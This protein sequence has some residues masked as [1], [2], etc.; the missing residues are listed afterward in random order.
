MANSLPGWSEVCEWTKEQLND[1]LCDIGMERSSG[2]KKE[3]RDLVFE[4]LAKSIERE[5]ESDYSVNEDDAHVSQSEETLLV[6]GSKEVNDHMSGTTD[7]EVEMKRMQL[8]KM[9]V[10]LR[11][12]EAKAREAQIREREA[13]E[14]ARLERLEREKRLKLLD[15][16]E[17]DRQNRAN[18]LDLNKYK[19]LPNF[20][21]DEIE[22]FFA[23]F[24]R[25][26]Q[27]LGWAKEHWHIIVGTVL[28]GKALE[29][30]QSLPI[31]D[32]RN[33]T[34]LKTEILKKYALT[35]EAYRQQFRGCR[36]NDQETFRQFADRIQS[37]FD[38]WCQSVGASGSFEKLREAV[39]VEQFNNSIGNNLKVY[40]AEREV[41]EIQ[42]AARLADN[43]SLIHGDANNRRPR[44]A[45]DRT[46]NK[47]GD[48]LPGGMESQSQSQRQSQRGR[49]RVR[50]RR[51]NLFTCYV[52][53][54]PG[55]W[56]RNC[57][58]RSAQV[59]ATVVAVPSVSFSKH[60]PGRNRRVPK[61]SAGSARVSVCGVPDRLQKCAGR[62]NGSPVE[63]MLDS[64][65]STV[66]VR[67][68]LV[69][70]DQVTGRSFHCRQFDGTTVDLPTAKVCLDT[71]VFKGLVEA[72]MIDHPVSDVI[73]G[74][75][76][77]AKFECVEVAG[78]ARRVNQAVQT[79]SVETRKQVR[80]EG[81]SVNE[82]LEKGE[83]GMKMEG[84]NGEKRV[85][86]DVNF[87]CGKVGIEKMDERRGMLAGRGMDESHES[88]EARSVG[89]VQCLD[90]RSLS[91]D[92]RME[93][94][95][96]SCMSGGMTVREETKERVQSSPAGF[97]GGKGQV[98]PVDYAFV[99]RFRE[100][101]LVELGKRIYAMWVA[102]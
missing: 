96:K 53:N 41:A 63:V 100:A 79:E 30:Y 57:P 33:Y 54:R 19:N 46:S 43:Y 15:L 27:E 42:E 80:V 59:T 35:T 49:E 99:E 48:P 22:T 81:K 47:F 9:Q 18:S 68:A 93:E 32:V 85:N 55:H 51:E 39:L 24:E 92:K 102:Q 82:R 77:G 28:T 14:N 21:E 83:R 10:E 34:T 12:A 13:E 64:G 94:Q 2:N 87:E 45:A 7:F 70:A 6:S 38:K 56:A 97:E 23:A 60:T 52:C 37:G 89:N 1:F 50:E 61:H 65:S 44:E 76:P 11:E 17:Q 71:P 67:K 86:A 73:L 8:R 16:E 20:S 25:Q 88:A 98:W 4:Y 40:L 95:G 69:S 3:L 36:K 5:R 91:A 84:M 101:F 74:R 72:C 29:V 26:A 90:R 78:D 62:L 66:G 31:L 58:V 75:I